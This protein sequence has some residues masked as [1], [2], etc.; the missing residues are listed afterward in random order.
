MREILSHEE[1]MASYSFRGNRRDVL[2]CRSPVTGW[3]YAFGV[4]RP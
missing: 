2:Y 3:C 1:G 4:L